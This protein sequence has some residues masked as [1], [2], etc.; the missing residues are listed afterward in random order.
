MSL[1]L[2]GRFDT[3]PGAVAVATGSYVQ[4]L[5]YNFVAKETCR[6]QVSARSGRYR[7][8]FCNE[9]FYILME[10]MSFDSHLTMLAAEHRLPFA[11]R[12]PFLLPLGERQPH[13]RE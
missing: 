10:R 12:S 2:V 6:K 3:E 13:S 9:R 8:R 5:I 1:T 11:V 7:S 4:P